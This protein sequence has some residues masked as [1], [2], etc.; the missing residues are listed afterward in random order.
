[1]DFTLK[2]TIFCRILFL[3]L[4][5]EPIVALPWLTRRDMTWGDSPGQALIDIGEAGLGAL[6]QLW[7]QLTIPS[8]ETVY[9]TEQSPSKPETPN[10]PEWL[11]PPLFEPN[12]M[13]KCSTSTDPIVGAPDDQL[14]GEGDIPT[15]NPNGL[16]L[17]P[18]EE[19]KGVFV[20]QNTKTG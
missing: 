10:P 17:V 2:I 1:M 8:T 20:Q 18:D 6:N 19:Y 14:P 12:M 7:N 3:I 15:P 5:L 11:T 9:P 13:K 4:V 16:T